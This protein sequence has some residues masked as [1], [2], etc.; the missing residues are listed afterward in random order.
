[1]GHSLQRLKDMSFF[2]V[3]APASNLEAK[4]EM[5]DVADVVRVA[6]VFKIGV[7]LVKVL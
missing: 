1:M 6:L 4:G 5:V 3:L 2:Q 7:N